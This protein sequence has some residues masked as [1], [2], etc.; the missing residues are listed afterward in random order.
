MK[1]QHRKENGIS[2]L[3]HTT[4]LQDLENAQQKSL[5]DCAVALQS[6]AELEKLAIENNQP[7]IGAYSGAMSA[8]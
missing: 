1:K 2:E 7:N 6:I 3:N 8:R 4:Q 5:D